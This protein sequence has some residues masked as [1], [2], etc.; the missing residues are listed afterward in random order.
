M[1]WVGDDNVALFTDLYEL[2]M[3]ASYHARGLNEPAT[4]DLFSR[5]LPPRR[6]YLIACGLEQALD[7]LERLSFGP[8]AL[9]YLRSLGTFDPS[10]LDRLA[11]L[12]FT[13]DVWA[14]PEGELVFGGEPIL[15]VTAPL[16]EAQIVETYLLNV[17]GF[18]T[19]VA[20]K[21]ARVAT[22]C[23]N[24]AFVDFSARR[25]HGADAALLAAR[26][27][28]V[29]GAVGTSLVLAGEAFGLPLSGTMAHSYV[30]RADDEEEALQA[31]A[32]DYG[33][34][35]VL[36][37]DTYD[38]EDGARQAVRI[39]ERL[40][41]DGRPIFRGVRL[42]SGDLASLAH[43]VRRIL[44]DGGLAEVEIFASGD[45]DEDR[46]A[47]L[48]A[49]DAPIDAFG[50]GTRLGTSADASHVDVVYKLAEDAG[51][52]KLKLSE[53]KATD[54]GRKQVHR[55]VVDGVA[56]HDVLALADERVDGAR[57][58]LA[59]VMA[60][61]RRTRTAETLDALRTRARA[62]VASFPARLRALDP[63][64]PPY[65][66]RRSSGLQ[67]LAAELTD[68]VTRDHRPSTT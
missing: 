55:V 66:V 60:G 44:D 40:Q 32:E 47:A 3:A 9:D 41:R 42:D 56:D 62:A 2:T 14:I 63:E 52:A 11:E 59:E 33:E 37:I 35:A 29:G 53:G 24:R 19:M 27:A 5:K 57:P 1:R 61:G 7:Y 65:E 31:F 8:D 58:L 38:T 50:V 49:A 16:I 21:A 28:A 39:A 4:F 15:R 25:D 13:G 43:S 18:Q 30:M 68:Q 6:G 26:A 22:A 10:F 34:H 17:V 46:I 67:D 12:E 64:G 20:S 45:L 36:L 54:P 23:G 48:V 51:H